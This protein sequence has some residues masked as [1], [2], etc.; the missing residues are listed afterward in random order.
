MPLFRLFDS[1]ATAELGILH[2]V[3]LFFFLL[4]CDKMGYIAKL[5]MLLLDKC[6]TSANGRNHRTLSINTYPKISNSDFLSK[7]SFLK[8]RTGRKIFFSV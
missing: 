5:G 3:L 6:L 2:A 1:A 4:C 7:S 8:L